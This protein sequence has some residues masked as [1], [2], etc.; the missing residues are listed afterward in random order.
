MKWPAVHHRVYTVGLF[1]FLLQERHEQCVSQDL[2]INS[3]N[4]VN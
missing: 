3:Q 4:L 1:I 2:D